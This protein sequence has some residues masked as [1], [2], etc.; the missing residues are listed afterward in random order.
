M[1]YII[2]NS[3]LSNLKKGNMNILKECADSKRLLDLKFLDLTNMINRVQTSVIFLSTISGFLNATKEQFGI[4][5]GIISVISI[6]IS[7]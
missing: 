6:S 3:E 1:Q 4:A 5:E 7:T 2:F